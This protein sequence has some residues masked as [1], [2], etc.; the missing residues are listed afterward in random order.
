[1]RSAELTVVSNPGAPLTPPLPGISSLVAPEDSGSELGVYVECVHAD[2]CGG[3]PILAL[4]Y[5]DQLSLKRGRVVNSLARYASLELS[6]TE[7]VAPAN[8]VTAYRT[9]AKLIV[10]PGGHV[11]LFAKGGGHQ[12]VD[13]DHCRVL[14]PMLSDVANV[15]RTEIRKDETNGACLAPFNSNGHGALRALDLREIDGEHKGVLLTWVLTRARITPDIR[16]QL[17]TRAQALLLANPTILGIALNLHDGESPQVLGTETEVLAG[18]GFASDRIGVA[19]QQATYGSFVQAHRNQ[20]A[21]IHEIVRRALN[22][23]ARGEGEALRILD[24]YGGSGAVALS[25]AQAGAQVHMVES[26]APAVAHAREAAANAKLPVTCECGDTG[27]VL[28]KLTKERRI[29]DG[30]VVNPPRR[31]MSPDA[32]RALAALAVPTIA[33]VSCDPET[34]ARDLDHFASLGYVSTNVQPFDMIPLTDEVETVVVLR[35]IALP[36][37]RILLDL[38]DLFSVEKGPHDAIDHAGHA[39]ATATATATATTRG[40]TLLAR[41]RAMDTMHD[42][43][44]LRGLDGSASGIVIFARNAAIAQEWLGSAASARTVY[45]AGA[46]G[47]MPSKGAIQRDLKERGNVRPARTRYRRL[48]VSGGHS[49]LRIIPDENATHQVRRHLAAM[50]HPVLG[51]ARY[52]HAPTNRFF[53]EKNALDRPFLHAIRVELEHPVNKTRIHFEVPLAGD[54]KAVLER[55]GGPG[56]IRFLEQ[57]QAL[58]SGSLPPPASSEVTIEFAPGSSVDFEVRSESIRP[59]ILSDDEDTLGRNRGES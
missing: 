20:A 17:E 3:C 25:L 12:V 23:D 19:L 6:Y 21:R 22:V 54:L 31:G 53:E 51:D 35:R 48:A 8:P 44:V 24:L 27:A 38:G 46:K 40:L 16:T 7:A 14:A 59:A 29:F 15:M 43:V 47:I 2:R 41:V 58:G 49:I 50:G 36:A 1:M 57:K 10:A 11:G 55:L 13:I 28:A 30:A 45:L 4:A 18:L 56:T 52:G 5:A 34:L 39:N 42:A 37:P 26:F 32:R 9:R 33:Y